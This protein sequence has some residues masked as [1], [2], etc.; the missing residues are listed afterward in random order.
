MTET[1]LQSDQALLEQF[2]R[3][4]VSAYERLV[5]RYDK[6]VFN[7]IRRM[8]DR[9]QEAE[10]LAQETFIRVYEQAQTLNETR[11][12]RSWLWSIAANL[13]R[14]YLKRQS[15]RDHL[16][17]DRDL[18]MDRDLGSF[19]SPDRD[20]EDREVGQIIDQAI[21]ALKTDQRM[22]VV[23]REYEGL[24]YEEIAETVGC[25]ISTVKSRLHT[26]RQELRERLAFLLDK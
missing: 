18:N 22:V 9:S 13:C 8:I 23:L 16:S 12:F 25:S 3:G 19:N 5:A 26:A 15:Y 11:A 17:L 4:D 6:P 20:L 14:D 21:A 2:V 10:D 7:F 24:P 1:C